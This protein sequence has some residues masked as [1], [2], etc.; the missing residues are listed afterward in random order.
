MRAL[1][2]KLL[3]WLLRNVVY[4][5]VVIAVL[6]GSSYLAQE[7]AALDKSSLDLKPLRDFRAAIDVLRAQAEAEL[8]ARLPSREATVEEIGARRDSLA[9]DLSRL[10]GERQ[11]LWNNH[12]VERYLPSSKVFR[13]LAERDIRIALLTQ[14]AGYA[15]RL[16]DLAAG[17]AH[18]EKQLAV[19]QR[20]MQ[21]IAVDLGKTAR[22]SAALVAAYPARV[23]VP[24]S[25]AWWQMRS[26]QD[27]RAALEKMRQESQQR[28]DTLQKLSTTLLRPRD[29]P[30][31][32]VNA[33]ALDAVL[34]PLDDE[35]ARIEALLERHWLQRIAAPIAAVLP[36][37]LL[38]LL[39]LMLAPFGIKLFAFHVVAPLAARRP[40]ICLLPATTGE[41][42]IVADAATTATAATDSTSVVRSIA[43]DADKELLVHPEYLRGV[44]DRAE[45]RTQWLLDAAMPFTSLA[46][47][48]VGLT[49]ISA[50]AAETVTLASTDPLS[51]IGIIDVPAAAAV[52]LQ[53][54]CLVGMLRPLHHP[55]HITR[56]WRLG[57]LS[58][59]LTLQ[60][61]YIVF[62]GP[63]RLIVKGCRGVRIEPVDA[64]RAV[65]QAATLGF[66]ANLTY[67]VSRCA[68]FGAYLMGKQEL[69]ND[70]WSGPS[71]FC[72][73]EEMPRAHARTGF[74]G[75]GL[76]GVLDTALKA[77]GV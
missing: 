70:R 46:A 66:S 58:S 18:T 57:C 23:Q 28:I 54:R 25:N 12:P 42:H 40:G 24:L 72:I 20:V 45:K 67:S 39:G 41:M 38:I 43:L 3:R 9:A 74:A 14:A 55:V 49:R 48:M 10:Q 33:T 53:P 51:E 27:E 65:N 35:I 15:G 73:H 50:P 59:W 11:A 34:R 56:H 29:V 7:W 60:L 63:V 64:G 30:L 36:T 68:T 17:L 76:E 21:S 2:G 32:A 31:F 13:E 19:H 26:L 44:S 52:V 75:R 77:F 71:G 47:G 61:R 22:A 8:V 6:L 4:L 16:H 37:A 69:F 1:A 5:M 62:H